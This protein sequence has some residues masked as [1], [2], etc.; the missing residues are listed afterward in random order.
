LRWSRVNWWK[1]RRR[2]RMVSAIEECERCADKVGWWMVVK[3]GQEGW[4]PAN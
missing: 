2:M 1:S 3:N 4:A